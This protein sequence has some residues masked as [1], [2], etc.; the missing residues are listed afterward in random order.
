MLVKS[1]LSSASWKKTGRMV[2]NY[3][4]YMTRSLDIANNF[5]LIPWESDGQEKETGISIHARKINNLK[6]ADDIDLLEEDRDKLKRINEA[7]K[8]A[9]LTINFEKKIMVF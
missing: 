7:G 9:G 5:Y 3:G 2:Q 1:K 6:F 8:A 4:W